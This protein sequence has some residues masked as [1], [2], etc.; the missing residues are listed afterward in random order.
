[1]SS[2]RT[3]RRA[4]SQPQHRPRPLVAGESAPAAGAG[5]QVVGA[6]PYGPAVQLKGAPT[7]DDVHRRAAEGVRG[8]PGSLPYSER[9]QTA[10]GRHDV[11]GVQA[12]VGGPAADASRAIGATA[13]AVGDQVAFRETPSLHTAAHEAAHVVQQRSGVHLKGGVG[14]AG[15]VYERHAD[16]VADAVVAGGTAEPLLDSMSTGGAGAASSAPAVQRHSAQE[17]AADV[18]H[19]HPENPA[20]VITSD[21]TGPDGVRRLKWND[22]E[23]AEIQPNG[24]TTWYRPNGSFGGSV[25]SATPAAEPGAAP[26]SAPGSPPAAA[27]GGRGDA[28]REAVWQAAQKWLKSQEEFMTQAKI[29]EV[30]GSK[31]SYST[32]RDFVTTVLGEARTATGESLDLNAVVTALQALLDKEIE[33]RATV[34]ADKK[35]EAMFDP[36]IT[37][38]Q[39]EIAALKEKGVSGG[40]V[41][42]L[43][44]YL[45]DMIAQRTKRAGKTA[46]DEAA[47]AKLDEGA[48]GYKRAT[49]GMPTSLRP[50]K[51]DILR[52]V[53]AETREYSVAGAAPST[54]QKGSFLHTSVFDRI[55]NLGGPNELWH[56]LDGGGTKATDGLSGA[57]TPFDPA[58]LR[59]GRAAL[60]GWID[61]AELVNANAAGPPGNPTVSV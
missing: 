22:G 37:R 32:C 23:T 9:I 52:I 5:S 18:A 53:T 56:T 46:K 11:S 58:T 4:P 35:S 61:M 3:H 55:D 15:D 45:D 57:G 42:A 8:A 34:E 17:P 13:Y 31:K 6:L 19:G 21:T 50:R 36:E 49:P 38:V 44:K 54:L 33:L 16:A 7:G 51:G 12:H 14:A 1:M 43:Q 28:V 47:L 25:K 29:D 60:E 2:E 27:T 20:A 41:K 48:K 10:F 59:F 26:E 40:K 30:R 24:D 39:A